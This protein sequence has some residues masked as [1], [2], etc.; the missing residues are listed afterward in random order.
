MATTLK[1]GSRDLVVERIEQNKAE[2]AVLV[3]H[4]PYGW[5]PRTDLSRLDLREVDL[6]GLDLSRAI[7][8]ESNLQNAELTDVDLTNAS[9]SGT[10]L[11]GAWMTRVNL[12]DAS[13]RHT[14]TTY[15][16]LAG[17]NLTGADL[18]HS[19]LT[20]WG[21]LVLLRVLPSGDAQL[22][23][24]P[25]GWAM[26]VGCWGG[27]PAELR[28]LVSQDEDW[29]EARGSQVAQRRP[30]LLALLDLVDFHTAQ[31][32]NQ[33]YLAAVTRQWGTK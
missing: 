1:R 15:L 4:G 22:V 19:G 20:G 11:R 16:E 24:T 18:R 31:R 7:F 5:D 29:P 3:E 9:F 13:L 21:V 2:R 27:T 17:A 26:R 12:T 32:D 14:R 28:E 30:G 25:A 8:S 6:R 10:D 23:P 33:D